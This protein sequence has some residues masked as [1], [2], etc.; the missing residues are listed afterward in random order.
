[1]DCDG[2][3]VETTGAGGSVSFDPVPATDHR[4]VVVSNGIAIYDKIVTVTEGNETLV[5]ASAALGALDV[6]VTQA[7]LPVV[8]VNAVVTHAAGTATVMTNAAGLARFPFLPEGSASIA[9]QTQLGTPLATGT[10]TI[11]AGTTAQRAFTVTLPTPQPPKSAVSA[12]SASTVQNPE[13]GT[14]TVSMANGQRTD[15]TLAFEATCGSGSTP[16]VVTVFYGMDSYTPTI[17][18]AGPGYTLTIPGAQLGFGGPVV[19]ETT[20]DGVAEADDLG[21][22]V[23]YDPSG[24]VTDAVSSDPVVGAEVYLYR[25]PGWSPRE[26]SADDGTPMTCQTNESKAPGAPWSQPAPIGD[27]VLE[28]SNS[29]RISPQVNPFVTDGVGYYGWDVAEGCWYITIDAPGY[30]S[31][32]SPVVGVPSEVTDLDVELQPTTT[33]PGAP[34]GVSAVVSAS[35]DTSVDVAWSA[36]AS[37]GNSVITGYTVSTSPASAGCSTTGAVTCTI[38]G[39]SPATMYTVTVVATNAVGSSAASRPVPRSPR[40]VSWCHPSMGPT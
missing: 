14:F 1:M 17:V 8:G 19:V 38:V 40:R 5:S 36:P 13:T 16:S 3:L 34:M 35:S 22:I 15:V 28:P 18:G 23:L 9:L 26:S 7:G 4:I 27:G 2:V 39:L 10:A 21:E 37:D 30:E 32:V 12:G 20:C 25:V 29:V 31:Y 11:V 6:T 24:L 33:V